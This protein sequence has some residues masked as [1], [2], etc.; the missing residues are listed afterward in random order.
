MRWGWLLVCVVAVLAGL[1]TF[2][3]RGLVDSYA[4]NRRLA[5]LQETNETLARENAALQ[6]TIDLL[7]GDLAYIE[8]VSRDDLGMVRKGDLVYRFPEAPGCP[9]QEQ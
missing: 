5:E 1:I 3:D 2:G 9:G 7:E 8:R 6:Q 4:M